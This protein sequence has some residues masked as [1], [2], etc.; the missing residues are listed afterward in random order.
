M[1]LPWMCAQYASCRED[2]FYIELLCG[3]FVAM[4]GH[5]AVCV[6]FQ[7]QQW[8]SDAGNGMPAPVE[9]E[10]SAVDTAA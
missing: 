3:C 8:S 6:T 2:S 7:A 4:L 5:R 9:G 1:I 10:H